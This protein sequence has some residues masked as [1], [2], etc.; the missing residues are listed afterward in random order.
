[1]LLS[2]L[3]D[4]LAPTFPAYVRK[5]LQ[6]AVRALARALKCADPQHCAFDHYNRPLPALYHLVENSTLHRI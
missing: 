1:M 4:Q 2:E 6:T 3:Y 5:D